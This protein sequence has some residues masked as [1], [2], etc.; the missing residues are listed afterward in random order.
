[1][2]NAAVLGCR[3]LQHHQS[4]V[5]WL[6][7]W[8]LGHRVPFRGPWTCSTPRI[9]PSP[10]WYPIMSDDNLDPVASHHRSDER[11]PYP[12][13]W[14]FDVPRVAGRKCRPTVSTTAAD[15]PLLQQIGM[16]VVQRRLEERCLFGRRNDSRGLTHSSRLPLAAPSRGLDGQSFCPGSRGIGLVGTGQC[17]M[18]RALPGQ[19]C[20]APRDR[21][22]LD[23][24]CWAWP[25]AELQRVVKS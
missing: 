19:A 16:R 8:P 4:S 12:G 2:S 20:Q 6:L 10:K 9:S 17:S 11:P 18:L 14:W 22:I 21:L 23:V 25:G 3:N 15:G 7:P 24:H 1:M 13:G 5:P